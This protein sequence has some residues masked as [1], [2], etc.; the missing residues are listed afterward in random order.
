M[1]HADLG[2]V[3]EDVQYLLATLPGHVTEVREIVEKGVGYLP[4]I[5]TIVVKAGAQ[6]PKVAAI[7]DKAVKY[8]PTVQA[9]VED[10]SLPILVARI[11]TLRSLEA[12]ARTDA[13]TKKKP[14]P[15]PAG[16]VGIGLHRFVKPLDMYI[17]FRT[18]PAKFYVGI[19]IAAVSVVG[20]GFL[21]GRLTKRCR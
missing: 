21:A 3:N 17:S 6:L 10:P 15:G 2:G 5:R 7:V 18:S 12:K 11:Q 8:L 19:G 9:I 16:P 13:V 14:Q 1:L 20:L 4:Q